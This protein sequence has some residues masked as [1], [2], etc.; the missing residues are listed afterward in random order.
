[1]ENPKVS[2]GRDINPS[3]RDNPKVSSGRDINPSRRDNPKVSSGRDINPSRRDNPKVSSGC[4]HLNKKIMEANPET[5][6][7]KVPSNTA[8]SNEEEK[9]DGTRLPDV[10]ASQEEQDNDDQGLTLIVPQIPYPTSSF[11]EPNQNADGDIPID[12]SL[13]EQ[14]NLNSLSLTQEPNNQ[15]EQIDYASYFNF[16]RNIFLSQ[17][18]AKLERL[19]SKKNSSSGI[20]PNAGKD[21]GRSFTST[22]NNF[23]DLTRRSAILHRTGLYNIST[24]APSGMPPAG[25]GGDSCNSTRTLQKV[26]EGKT[27]LNRKDFYKPDPELIS[28]VNPYLPPSFQLNGSAAY[29]LKSSSSDTE[30]NSRLKKPAPSLQFLRDNF[31]NPT[32]GPKARLLFFDTNPHNNS[33]NIKKAQNFK[34][35]HSGNKK[36]VFSPAPTP[37]STPNQQ[38]ATRPSDLVKTSGQAPIPTLHNSHNSANMSYLGGTSNIYNSVTSLSRVQEKEELQRL[39]DRFSAYVGRVRQLGEQ[40]NNVD[41]SAFLRS[42]K[43]LEEEIVNLKNMYESELERLR[44][45]I[46]AGS[47]ERNTL[48]VQHNKQ[49]QYV[50]ELQDRLSIETEKTNK[51]MDEINMLERQIGNLQAEV[52]D[53]RIASQRPQENVDNLHRSIENLMREV[54]QWKH[55][56]EHEQVTRQEAEDRVQQIFK[57]MEFAEQIHKQQ[58]TD[59]QTRLDTASATILSLEARVRDLSKADVSVA[60]MLK[61]VRDT[62]EV[63]LKKFQIES[64]EQYSRNLSALKAQIDHDADTLQRYSQEKSEMMGQVGE[65]HAKIRNLE[66]QVANLHHQKET[67]E[68]A[69][70]VERNRAADNIRQL[71]RKLRE[72]Q[73]MLV[74]KMRE[75]TNA[76]EANIPLKAEI[77]ALK[78]ILEEEERRL[79]VPLGIVPASVVQTQVPHP[80]T[81]NQILS[82]NSLNA[83]KAAVANQLQPSEGQVNQQS[84][85]DSKKANALQDVMS[86]GSVAN[87]LS[88]LLESTHLY[89]S[90]AATSAEQTNTTAA[91]NYSSNSPLA[92]GLTSTYQYEPPMPL[93]TL[94]IPEALRSAE[95][96]QVEYD[97]DYGFSYPEYSSYMQGY[98]LPMTGP[99]YTYEATPSV[100]RVMMDTTS[101]QT[102][103]AVGPIPA[104][105]KSA[106][107][108]T[109]NDEKAETELNEKSAS[110]AT[111]ALGV[112][113]DYFD[114]MFHD[115]KRDTLFPKS[116]PKSSPLERSVPSSFQDYS[117]TTSSAIGDL[118]VLEVNQDG[119]YVRLVNDGPTEFEF[120]GYMIQQNVGG[121]P[122][123]VFRFPP[124][125]KFMPDST[126]TVWAGVNDPRLNNPPT[127]FYW[128]EHQKWGSGPECT[129]ILC[130]PNGQAVAWSTA[131]H[132]VKKDAFEEKPVSRNDTEFKTNKKEETEPRDDE[133]SL[134]EYNTDIIGIK[135]EQPV[136]LRREKQQPPTLSA[137]KHP[138]GHQPK[139]YVHPHTGVERPV[140][141]G[142][143]NSTI[144]RQSRAQSCRPDPIP[145]QPFCGAPAQRMG[146]APLRMMGGNQG[147]HPPTIRGNGTLANKSTSLSDAPSPFM[148]P[149]NRF[150]TGLEQIRSQHQLQFIPPMPHTPLLL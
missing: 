149:H 13:V 55:R 54:D 46:E 148:R 62:A 1:R 117:V 129:T 84:L 51:L 96:G 63:E 65:L 18:A 67:L 109:D 73:D 11:Q 24:V 106:P 27:D 80:P 37:P 40:V 126:I 70:S 98:A 50:G 60:E 112:G 7:E 74:T 8:V 95:E 121:H 19:A 6:S 71:E 23:A 41:T 72:V 3:R 147:Q 101:M 115:L 87:A 145:G 91:V 47:H 86:L 66:G 138:H 5:K 102:P 104:R 34:E 128:K 131:A 39:N 99:G 17:Q 146:S 141:F 124:R 116:R 61:Q 125:T 136:Y 88:P 14:E 52:Q 43:I 93:N 119:K 120:G 12:T 29:Q 83:L 9:T 20:N 49:Q 2:S 94:Y 133:D 69:V 36:V 22:R 134:T 142:N 85:A 35:E 68:D 33:Q 76:R 28:T 57:K 123:A 31:L 108:H 58:I 97:T 127:D 15:R 122:V 16:S 21:R 143:D 113:R 132:R 78:A 105:S 92:S 4:S 89:T 110:L 38:R 81:T 139:A 25:K 64:E 103:R 26:E 144:S 100:S 75:V 30:V 53:A 82:T 79:R 77:E 114:E 45:E 59:Y 56:Y 135:H 10:N 42:T 32:P 107:N 111:T 150:A 118:K 90:G 44:N 137:S 140:Y 48:Y 130:R